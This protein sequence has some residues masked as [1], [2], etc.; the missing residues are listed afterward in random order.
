MVG[1]IFMCYK[2][3]VKNKF[4]F[5]WDAGRKKKPG[6]KKP[7]IG[8]DIAREG[9]NDKE[10]GELNGNMSPRP[11]IQLVRE[12]PSNTYH[13][14]EMDR[15]RSID[16]QYPRV[17]CMNSTNSLGLQNNPWSAA[18]LGVGEPRNRLSPTSSPVYCI[19]P[20][21]NT[22]AERSSELTL[23]T[24][25]LSRVNRTRQVTVGT[26]P[27]SE[28]GV[29][30]LQSSITGGNVSMD[31][32]GSLRRT[33]SPPRIIETTTIRRSQLGCASFVSSGELD[34][35]A[36]LSEFEEFDGDVIMSSA[37]GNQLPQSLEQRTSF[38]VGQ[39]EDPS[40][41]VEVEL[42]SDTA[43]NYSESSSVISVPCSTG[44]ARQNFSNHHQFEQNTLR[45]T[46]Q[47]VPRPVRPVSH[48]QIYSTQIISGARNDIIDCPLYRPSSYPPDTTPRTV[49]ICRSI[50]PQPSI[51]PGPE[52]CPASVILTLIPGHST[53]ST[54][55]IVLDDAGDSNL[56]V[57]DRSSWTINPPQSQSSH[58]GSAPLTER[59]GEI[60]ANAFTSTQIHA[61]QRSSPLES[62]IRTHTPYPEHDDPLN[63]CD[64]EGLEWGGNHRAQAVSA[65]IQA[66]PSVWDDPDFVSVADAKTEYTRDDNGESIAEGYEGR[67]SVPI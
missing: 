5:V 59:Q 49:R 27:H 14:M 15:V 9:N 46:S 10:K 1:V 29:G 61:V 67:S 57:R 18:S 66:A 16:S 26:S 42:M 52:R 47:A 36:V 65:W 23:A 58:S 40:T 44:D 31:N 22:G 35:S 6:G 54:M 28:R 2:Y 37:C 64:G 38:R 20:K 48:A 12:L 41:P 56:S 63:Y 19:T 24:P 21:G 8:R 43:G 53:P 4:R 30:T 60:R 32:I 34:G 13:E 45:G 11:S 55:N 39:N 17:V 51:H 25:L 7:L 33:I 50:S 3:C 62:L